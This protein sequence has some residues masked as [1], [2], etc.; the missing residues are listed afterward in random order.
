MKPIARTPAAA[1]PQQPETSRYFAK[2]SFKLAGYK[3]FV[4]WRK[5]E[6]IKQ[7]CAK[8]RKFWSYSFM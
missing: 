8:G 2:N 3:K 6:K 5:G 1:K 7:K 4:N